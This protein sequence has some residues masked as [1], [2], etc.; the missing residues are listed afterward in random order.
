L[1]APFKNTPPTFA[2]LELLANSNHNLGLIVMSAKVKSR[3][4]DEEEESLE[5][6]AQRRRE[7]EE[8]M[9]VKEEK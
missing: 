1:L 8:K 3:W 6:I 5:A 4:T 9:R 7:K 2:I